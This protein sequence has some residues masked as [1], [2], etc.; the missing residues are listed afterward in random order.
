LPIVHVAGGVSEIKK[1]EIPAAIEGGAYTK[2]RTVRSNARYQGAR[3]KRAR[4]KAEAE[5]AK[6]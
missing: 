1:S 3:E 6:K 5:T 4:D 2:L